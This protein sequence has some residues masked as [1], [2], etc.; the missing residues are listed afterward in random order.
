MSGHS[1]SKK[2]VPCLT[3]SQYLQSGCVEDN[4]LFLETNCIL[5]YA[6]LGFISSSQF[7][8]KVCCVCFMFTLQRNKIGSIA[9]ILRTSQLAIFLSSLLRVFS[10][11]LP[12]FFHFPHCVSLHL[13]A[14]NLKSTLNH[15][16]HT[17]SD[18][19]CNI[20]LRGK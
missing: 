14:E 6:V 16:P 4:T 11:E 19:V 7:T 13:E 2:L 9:K 8:S 1:S 12:I 17:I 10:A 15:R 5:L 20:P 3:R 18:L